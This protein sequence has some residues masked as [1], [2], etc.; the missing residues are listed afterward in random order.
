MDI[1]DFNKV[2]RDKIEKKAYE[3]L[4]VVKLDDDSYLIN[5][6]SS[7][8]DDIEYDFIKD[9]RFNE[10]LADQIKE[11]KCKEDDCLSVTIK[12][13]NENDKNVLELVNLS[14]EE[15]IELNVDMNLD[16]DTRG[17]IVNCIAY[18]LDKDDL[19]VSF[20]LHYNFEL[21]RDLVELI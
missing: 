21:L 2:Y 3:S 1:I 17:K 15:V 5:D 8:S 13:Y 4:S 19:A 7:F 10:E 18:N 14:S 16:Y 12:Y 6:N 9:S 11:M 20:Y